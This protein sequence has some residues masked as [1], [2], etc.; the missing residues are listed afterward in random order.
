MSRRSDRFNTVS[1]RIALACG[2]RFVAH[3]ARRRVHAGK[4]EPPKLLRVGTGSART[5]GHDP[6][7]DSRSRAHKGPKSGHL[8]FHGKPFEMGEHLVDVQHVGIFVMQVEQIDLVA[9]QRQR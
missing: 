8:A 7:I 4:Q 9:Q 1:R 3:T 2:N 6:H 5:S